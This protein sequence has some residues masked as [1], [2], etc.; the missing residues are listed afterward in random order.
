MTNIIEK[1]PKLSLLVNFEEKPSSLLEE[2]VCCIYDGWLSIAIGSRYG[3]EIFAYICHKYQINSNQMSVHVPYIKK[4]HGSYIG[5]SWSKTDRVVHTSVKNSQK[6]Q[7][8]WGQNCERKTVLSRIWSIWQQY[9][10]FIGSG[11]KNSVLK[12]FGNQQAAARL[13]LYYTP[14]KPAFILTCSNPQ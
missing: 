3:M 11:Q 1:P 13:Y 8:S 14:F 10:H 2:S 7:W 12:T 9:I 4:I 6:W 5:W